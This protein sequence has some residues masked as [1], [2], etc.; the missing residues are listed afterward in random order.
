[1]AQP[2]AYTRQYNFNDFATTSPSDPL[3]GVQVDNELNSVK[4][5]LDGINTN[6]GLIQRDDGK[7]ANQS[8]HKN[9]FD[10]DAL[11]LIGLS[12]YTVSG[13]WSASQ[14]YTAGT[15]VD[16]N[17]ATYLAT[18]AH[19]SGTVFA[20]DQAAGK[21]ILLANAAINTSGSA[22]DKFEGDGQQTQFTLSYSYSSTTDFLVFVNGA[23]RNPNDDY[24]VS[25][26]TLTLATPPST[27][28]VSGNEN[29]I[30]WG[31]NIATEASKQ[32]A[33]TSASNASGFATAAQN[34]QTAAEL[35]LDTF[36]DRFLGA[37]PS[38]PTLDNDNN[39]LLT[40]ALYWN[41][42]NNE[43]LA[44]SGS[45]WIAIKPSTSEQ[46]NI[47]TVANLNSEITSLSGL[48][49]EITAL[50]GIKTEIATVDSISAE[51][52][53]VAAVATEVGNA[54]ANATLA[55]NYATE[56]DSP[57]TG[58]QDDSAKSWAIGGDETNYNMRTSGKGSA[59]EWATY[60]QGTCDGQDYSA[61]EYAIGDQR[62]NQAGGGSAK[63]WAIYMGGTVDNTDYSA[64]YW[65]NQ[66][67]NSVAT[68]DEKYYGAYA[69]DSA[70]ETG[71]TTAGGTVSAGDLY[72]STSENKLRFYNGTSWANIEATDTSDFANKGF[73]IAMAIAL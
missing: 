43:M 21:W 2:T 44:Y 4:T 1:M 38:D 49:S 63:D 37:K 51:I 12:G 73:A 13:T 18:V 67:A 70:A 42:A 22:V 9:S 52:Q 31:A 56:I 20:T 35:A 57:V 61:K 17:D 68:F 29:V 45:A 69:S 23:L 24:T 41:T 36:D 34:A 66:A 72:F 32:A 47:N 50:D 8:V 64:K 27:P 26:T 71:H 60:V 58:T 16:F 6:I 39:A 5:N 19:T 11:A 15:L 65:A 40:G 53:D 46:A 59:K 54:S 55:Q 48:T 10:T 33:A 7:L 28:S 3:P 30:V 62:R 14:A 25:G